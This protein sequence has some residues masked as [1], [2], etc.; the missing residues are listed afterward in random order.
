M[1]TSF[2][3]IVPYHFSL[4]TRFFKFSP[5]QNPF[6][7]HPSDT[8]TGKKSP[9]LF[10][11]RRRH[12]VLHAVML[13]GALGVVEAVERAHQIARDAANP[14]ERHVAE[15]VGQFH[16]VAIH[17]NVHRKRLAVVLLARMIHIGVNLRLRQGSLRHVHLAAHRYFSSLWY[18]LENQQ[19][20]NLVVARRYHA[21]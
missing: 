10:L 15:I 21:I 3:S 16:F 11:H 4:S 18:S 2:S 12:S 20:L 1:K 19:A 7:R 17:R 13:L 8:R 6:G 9:C 14:L 5:K